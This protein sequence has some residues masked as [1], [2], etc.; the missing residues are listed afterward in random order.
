MYDQTVLFNEPNDNDPPPGSSLVEISEGDRR[1]YY[2]FERL[3][4]F[5][6]TFAKGENNCKTK[7]KLWGSTID[8]WDDTSEFTAPTKSWYKGHHKEFNKWCLEHKGVPLV[9]STGSDNHEGGLYIA[10]APEQV[11]TFRKEFLN[12][13]ASGVAQATNLR[14]SVLENDP[15][16][17]AGRGSRINVDLIE[18][19]D[20]Y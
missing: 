13:Y 14:Q 1:K 15:E 17:E 6:D 12:P 3:Y 4:W 11:V 5:I 7:D 2:L 9:F 18:A 16:L 19:G 20:E 8:M 10:N